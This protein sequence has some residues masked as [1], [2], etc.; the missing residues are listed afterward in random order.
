M[1][2]IGAPLGML[3]EPTWDAGAIALPEEWSLLLY[4]DGLVEGLDGP[5]S[6]RRFGA[7]RL[8]GELASLAPVPARVTD[9]ALDVLL[10]RVKEAN[11]GDL[12]DDVGM[13]FVRCVPVAV[14]ESEEGRQ[15]MTISLRLPVERASVRLAR[16]AVEELCGR[17]HVPLHVRANLRL[18]VTEACANVVLH[19]YPTPQAGEF[20]VDARA[21]PGESVEVVVRDFGGGMERESATPGAGLGLSLIGTLTSHH[22]IRPAARAGGTEVVMTFGLQTDHEPA[23]QAPRGAHAIVRIAAR[24]GMDRLNRAVRPPE[25]L[26]SRGTQSSSRRRP[27]SSLP[28]CTAVAAAFGP[29]LLDVIRDPAV[30]MDREGAVV[31]ANE[32]FCLLTGFEAR[33]LLQSG[34]SWPWIPEDERGRADAVGADVTAVGRG[35]HPLLYRRRDGERFACWSTRSWCSTRTWPSASC[36]RRGASTARRSGPTSTPCSAGSARPSPAAARRARSTTWR[37]ARRCGCAPP[38]PARSCGSR[39]RPRRPC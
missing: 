8:A 24:S 10:D 35:R 20:E 6:A 13:L 16:H 32:A 21:V 9:R 14:A 7:S 26:E 36:S 4:T 27:P 34:D 25:A 38:T 30:L 11:G 17:L 31:H 29:A 39:G 19:A 22:E 18:A 2:P 12:A 5:T 3:P 15:D 1:V 33:E 37:C 28:P 23:R